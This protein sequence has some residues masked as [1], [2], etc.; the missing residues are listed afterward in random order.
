MK[1]EEKERGYKR[2][3]TKGGIVREFEMKIG[4]K[5]HDRKTEGRSRLEGD[6]G[7]RGKRRKAKF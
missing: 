2:V 1:E 3:K 4:K 7:G 5:K 6:G